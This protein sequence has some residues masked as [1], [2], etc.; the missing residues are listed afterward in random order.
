MQSAFAKVPEAD[1]GGGLNSIHIRGTH[2][3]G[4]GAVHSIKSTHFRIS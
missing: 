1:N 2:V 4:G 3:P